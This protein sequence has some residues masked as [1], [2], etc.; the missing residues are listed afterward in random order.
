MVMFLNV[1]FGAFLLIQSS[2]TDKKYL[3]STVVSFVFI[4]I[5]FLVFRYQVR[6]KDN[7][8]QNI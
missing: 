7:V 5:P 8:Q 2:G 1:T 6:L 4:N 3:H